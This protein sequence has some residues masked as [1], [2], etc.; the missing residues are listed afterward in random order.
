VTIGVTG[1]DIFVD[2]DTGDIRLTEKPLIT[3]SVA[4]D[5]KSTYVT[6]IEGVSQPAG[7]GRITL[8]DR[9]FDVVPGRFGGLLNE[10][11]DPDLTILGTYE[12]GLTRAVRD[13][14]GNIYEYFDEDFNGS[15]IGRIAL[16]YDKYSGLYAAYSYDDDQVTVRVYEGAYT[17]TG[18]AILI[19][20]N[21][22]LNRM[23]NVYDHNG[24]VTDLAVPE[25]GWVLR[26]TAV[27]STDGSTVMVSRIHD[28]EGRITRENDLISGTYRVFEYHT[29][30][31]PK[32]VRLSETR[33]SEDDSLVSS[34]EYL[35]NG[36]IYIMNT[37]VKTT[38][39]YTGIGRALPKREI[40]SDGSIVEYLGEDHN[41][42]GKGRKV[43]EYTADEGRYLVYEWGK[44]Q[45]TVDAYAGIYTTASSEGILEGLKPLERVASYVY[46]HDG[47]MLST[48]PSI[49]G[50][51]MREEKVYSVDGSTVSEYRSYGEA[52]EKTREQ[53]IATAA[54]TTYT[55]YEEGQTKTAAEYDARTGLMTKLFQYDE[56]GI[57]IGGPGSELTLVQGVSETYTT[58]MLKRKTLNSGAIYEYYEE[59]FAGQGFGR[60]S[61]VY[62]PEEHRY[63]RY[64]W[65][66]NMVEV[67]VYS[68]DYT[69][70]AGAAAGAG[71]QPDELVATYTYYHN[72]ENRDL[73]PIANGWI[74]AY[75][76][77][78][79]D[80][81]ISV[82][83][84]WEYDT[85]GRLVTMDDLTTGRKH[86]YTYLEASEGLV[87]SVASSEERY[88]ITG[89][90][91][92]RVLYS[93]SGKVVLT[94]NGDTGV[95]TEYHPWTG[96]VKRQTLDG[97]L[98]EY[99]DAEYGDMGRGRVI[100]LYDE[101]KG[102]YKTYDWDNEEVKVTEFYG[103][104]FIQAGD[105]TRSGVVP[106]HKTDEYTYAHGG[107]CEALETV[108]NGWI[109]KEKMTT[110]EGGVVV[111]DTFAPDGM[112][113]R[114]DY[115]GDGTYRVYQRYAE[116]FSDVVRF[117]YV[118]DGTVRPTISTVKEYGTD[119]NYLFTD[120]STGASYESTYYGFVDIDGKLYDCVVAQDTGAVSVREKG[121]SLK[122]IVYEVEYDTARDVYLF[123]DS[124]EE[125]GV[126][127]TSTSD[128]YV[129]VNDDLYMIEADPDGTISL[130]ERTV[131]LDIKAYYISRRAD[132]AFV[133]VDKT[134]GTRYTSVTRDGVTSISIAGK[135]FKLTL[136]PSGAIRLVALPKDDVNADGK[137]DSEDVT[138]INSNIALQSRINKAD[139]NSDG[140]V[141]FKDWD[142]LKT[143]V[144]AYEM[145][146]DLLPIDL[147]N[148]QKLRDMANYAYN[149]Y[150]QNKALEFDYRVNTAATS[151][152]KQNAPDKMNDGYI[153]WE[154]VQDFIEAYDS[155][156]VL[157]D[158]TQDG[159]IDERDA[160]W[161]SKLLAIKDI[162]EKYTAK[163]KM[164]LQ[165]AMDVAD[166]NKDGKVDETDREMILNSYDHY[167]ESDV[168]GDGKVDSVDIDMI[169][170]IYEV[171]W[172]GSYN[173]SRE[174]AIA[175]A[176]WPDGGS[177]RGES[178]L[179][180]RV[181]AEKCQKEGFTVTADRQSARATVTDSYLT[182]TFDAAETDEYF[183][184]LSVRQIPGQSVPAGHKYLVWVYV[185][186][187]FAGSMLINAAQDRYQ[188]NSFELPLTKGSHEIKYVF[189]NL[190][191]QIGVEV[192][193]VYANRSG[194][195]L[196]NFD[197][198]RDGA[199]TKQD[200]ET[201]AAIVT[202]YDLNEDLKVD[203]D[204]VGY[205][206]SLMNRTGLDAGFDARVDFNNDGVI[207]DKDRAVITEVIENN[208]NNSDGKLENNLNLP[209]NDVDR[210]MDLA[211][212]YM[213]EK[214]YQV[215]GDRYLMDMN[216]D[217]D[218]DLRDAA[219]YADA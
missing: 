71:I 5:V 131:S 192:K 56:D 117:E 38:V 173:E 107:E 99:E 153:E 169:R 87:S 75:A 176:R 9:V 212:F 140:R 206:S 188:E 157:F 3:E 144:E 138:V 62:D 112:L 128:G 7:T 216:G 47:N 139:M 205:V 17:T 207:D 57:Q 83:K 73:D 127:Y 133:M 86:L 34:V 90:L 213:T 96:L 92:E 32:V 106:A 217:G 43:L 53:V 197:T 113:V 10:N 12:S 64:T 15:G 201:L 80:D 125:D 68:G 162:A 94:E 202:A 46:D 171:V 27:Y 160:Q 203:A 198:N 20:V 145:K 126:V 154:D 190:S 136:E 210:I 195:T 14:Y 41:G 115:P 91:V 76:I 186:G 1:F 159:L 168:T 66:T 146:D 209:D 104:Y 50:W 36:E 166:I 40:L 177:R 172:P 81:H 26:Q 33:S 67:S 21:E 77:E 121:I 161:L 158:Y 183:I 69:V 102:I 199:I 135:M 151:W 6:I 111:M 58:D 60:V 79:A 72:F 156:G 182:R 78:Y 35:S 219:Y 54:Y 181:Y 2:P 150:L 82:R 116:P 163:G 4:G 8:R 95:I 129:N 194:L 24:Q 204:D 88:I 70:Q 149:T 196:T 167:L 11:T 142:N 93:A 37:P 174:E 100:L 51:T 29:S 164:F 105:V 16:M 44:D 89:G 179:A 130:R 31:D 98:Y 187:R 55:Y 134:D 13:I 28:E 103:E 61:L 101:E 137:V 110:L 191:A 184:G 59:D 30:P 141:D 85:E 178:V 65:S 108:T 165:T 170:E 152:I 74:P 63:S 123:R 215:I 124:S 143:V 114:R 49:A 193:D 189:K 218:I 22:A 39:Y 18:D 42:T 180:G 97:I 148:T 175:P 211:I 132:G 25:N 48:D 147:A 45:V 118:F 208:D 19:G 122:G 185:D 23:T 155:L 119:R 200:A 109:L 120:I 84:S 214:A 52:G